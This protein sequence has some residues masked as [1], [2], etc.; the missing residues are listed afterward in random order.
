MKHKQHRS[1]VKILPETAIPLP[2]FPCHHITPSGDIYSTKGRAI[3]RRKYGSNAAGYWTCA[4]RH[5]SGEVRQP[6]VHRLVALL[7]VPGDHSLEVN[8]KDLN[9]HNNAAANLEWVTH[10]GNLLHAR[11]LKTWEN[12]VALRPLIATNP[13]TGEQMRFESVKAAALWCGR[14][15]MAGNI[16]KAAQSGKLAYGRRWSYV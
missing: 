12:N 13:E 8:H 16:C 6:F 5:E 4:M 3:I 11:S 1:T 7:F 9:K 2:G 14:A 10:R 15:T